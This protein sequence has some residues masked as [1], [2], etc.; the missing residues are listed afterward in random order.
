MKTFRTST[1]SLHTRD[2]DYFLEMEIFLFKLSID[3]VVNI[4]FSPLSL[5][6]VGPISH[7]SGSSV[8]IKLEGFLKGRTVEKILKSLDELLCKINID[9]E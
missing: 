1:L 2:A 4:D 6:R 3:D 9:T 7:V 8:K 5:E